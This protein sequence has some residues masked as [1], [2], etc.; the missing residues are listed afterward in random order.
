M[1]GL[2]IGIAWFGYSI[3]YYGVTQVQG[4]NW[5]LLDLMVPSRWATAAA[6]VTDAG[7]HKEASTVGGPAGT[8]VAGD[9]AIA[10]ALNP[11]TIISG[12]KR[13]A[14]SIR[15]LFKTAGGLI[16]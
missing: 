12:D 11:S 5:G 2:G 4:G 6:T 3:L 16:P 7:T 10:N 1:A 14:I 13:I 8:V 15:N 9:K